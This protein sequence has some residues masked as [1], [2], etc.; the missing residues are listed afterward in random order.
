[1]RGGAGLAEV[2]CSSPCSAMDLPLS[3]DWPA[4]IVFR[5]WFLLINSWHLEFCRHTELTMGA[6]ESQSEEWDS[7]DAEYLLVG[8]D[9]SYMAV[10]MKRGY[11]LRMQ[12][13]CP[14]PL[15]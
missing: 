13:D 5:S 14:C 7:A 11:S 4:V 3:A 12:R 6:K 2:D 10:G 8:E 1:M 15:L 9:G